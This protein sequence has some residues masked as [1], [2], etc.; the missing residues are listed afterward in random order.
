VSRQAIC[1]SSHAR[2]ATC[3]RDFLRFLHKLDDKSLKYAVDMNYS[4]K[5][6]AGFAR[7]I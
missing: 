1:A 2:K 5:I 7:F 3:R 4:S 6:S